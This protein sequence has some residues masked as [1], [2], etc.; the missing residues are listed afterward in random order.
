MQ[1]EN[2]KWYN[3]ELDKE[4]HSTNVLNFSNANR[5]RSNIENGSTSLIIDEE[6]IARVTTMKYLSVEIAEKLNFK[7]HV[8]TTIKKMAKKVGFL[9][10]IQLELTK[11]AKITIYN[12]IISPHLDYCSSILFLATEEYLNRMQIIQNRAMRIILRCHVK[13]MLD[14]LECQSTKQRTLVFIFK[15]KHNM[16]PRLSYIQIAVH[17]RSYSYTTRMLMI[18]ICHGTTGHTHKTLYG[19]LN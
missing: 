13:T 3:H 2:R 6:Q 12:R 15:I 14:N 10:R 17:K 18:F 1:P 5:R 9:G 7:Q 4:F 11:T 8:D 19:M 16:G